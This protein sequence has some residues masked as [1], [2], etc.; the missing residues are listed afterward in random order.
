MKRP[1]VDRAV[2]EKTQHDLP[3]AP[4]ECRQGGAAGNAEPAADNAVGTEHANRK[5]RDVHAAAFPSTVAVDTAK[6]LGHHPA[7][8]GALGDGVA[9]TA[10]RARNLIGWL[11]RRAGA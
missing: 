4:H 3:A 5:V 10:V 1:L 11:E 2:A 7:Y 8:V 6:Q 9:M